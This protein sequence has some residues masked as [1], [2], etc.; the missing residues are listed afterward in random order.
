MQLAAQNKQHDNSEKSA[1][2][3]VRTLIDNRPC[4]LLAF[5]W[6]QQAHAEKPESSSPKLGTECPRAL[7]PSRDENGLPNATPLRATPVPFV[8][9]AGFAFV[10]TSVM[11]PP[12]LRNCC[13]GRLP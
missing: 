12:L 11:A 8:V 1:M 5:G 4:R 9:A 3:R 2:G 7:T 6:R 10:S 13:R